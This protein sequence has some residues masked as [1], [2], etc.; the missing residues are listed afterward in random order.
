MNVTQ[1]HIGANIKRTALATATMGALLLF[2]GTAVPQV[3][4]AQDRDAQHEVH[5]KY[6]KGMEKCQRRI[7]KAEAKLTEE[8]REHGNG[9]RQANRA[10]LELRGERQRCYTAYHQWWDGRDQQW[11]MNKDWDRDPRG[12]HDDH[13]RDRHPGGPGAHL[14]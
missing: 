9:S 7:E 11:R 6:N 8:M 13:D 2:V 5:Q 1:N 12:D 4:H 10:W 3:A 14:Q